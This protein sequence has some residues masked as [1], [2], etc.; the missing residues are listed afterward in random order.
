[1]N[2]LGQRIVPPK[3][4]QPGVPTLALNPLCVN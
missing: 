3:R 1:L 4:A 2:I